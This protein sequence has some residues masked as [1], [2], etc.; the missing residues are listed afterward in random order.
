[1]EIDHFNNSISNLLNFK[2]KKMKKQILFLLVL[3]ITLA[4]CQSAAETANTPVAAVVQATEIAP[5]ETAVP[6][7]DTPEP[8]AIPTE[9]AVP[10]DTP[11]PTAVSDPKTLTYLTYHGSRASGNWE[12]D[13]FATYLELNPHVTGDMI[14]FSLY[15]NPV[16]RNIH[17]RITR[18]DPADV[19]T[20]YIVGNLRQYVADGLIADISDLWA[21]QGWD[22]VFPASV[23]ELVTINGKQYF[24]PQAA[25]WN[26][27]FYRADI[28][29]EVG[30]T[31]P[32][33]WDE[34]LAACDTLNE[35]GIT[36]ITLAMNSWPPPAGFWFTP[37]T[38]AATSPISTKHLCVATSIT[39]MP[40]S[41]LSLNI[42]S[43][44][45]TTIALHS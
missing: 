12:D 1:L 24:V 15:S 9:T 18:E 30:L 3:L 28:F 32:T 35:A 29:A 6:P 2:E 37:S 43:R 25:Q 41:G 26:P 27:I 20:G 31:P 21:E 11:E 42:G 10:T 8:T 16:P 38:C 4:A 45:S 17:G 5:T 44:Y 39:T 33:T 40:T 14:K 22:N 7:T 23:K 34:L 13:N 36:P 19:I